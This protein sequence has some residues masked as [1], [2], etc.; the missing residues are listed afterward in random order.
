VNQFKLD[1]RL[2]KED[3]QMDTHRFVRLD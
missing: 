2:T 1:Q 3:Q